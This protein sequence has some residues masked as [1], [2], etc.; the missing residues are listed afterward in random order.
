MSTQKDIC[1]EHMKEVYR[2]TAHSINLTCELNTRNK[3]KE[4]E[5]KWKIWRKQTAIVD[6]SR[7][8]ME[9]SPSLNK[10]PA[11][12]PYVLVY[13]ATGR[14]VYSESWNRGWMKRNLSTHFSWHVPGRR[15]LLWCFTHA[16][17]L[18][19]ENQELPWMMKFCTYLSCPKTRSNWIPCNRLISV[20]QVCYWNPNMSNGHVHN[21]CM[22]IMVKCGS[23]L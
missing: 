15:G 6:S 1:Y 19:Q 20:I 21:G 14:T 8:P 7:K 18:F 16:R 22:S 11:E 5:K 9:P 12:V 3:Q 17:S 10:L 23:A 2:E 4:K 13:A